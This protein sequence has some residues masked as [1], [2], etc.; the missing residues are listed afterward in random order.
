MCLDGCL[1]RFPNTMKLFKFTL[2]ILKTTSEDERG[3]STMNLLVSPLRTLLNDVNVDRLIR[4]CLDGPSK[5]SDN[6]LEQ[7]V[8][9][10]RDSNN[11]RIVL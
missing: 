9:I 2:L 4:I 10:F 1:S 3:F 11:A 7:M 5:F 8:D 6:E